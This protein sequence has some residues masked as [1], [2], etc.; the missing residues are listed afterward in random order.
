VSIKAPAASF[1]ATAASI[2]F[3]TISS[4][5]FNLPL[6]IQILVHFF[7]AVIKAG[8]ICTKC[9]ICYLTSIDLTKLKVKLLLN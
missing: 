1:K 3:A 5:A 2:S 4:K 8:Q 6:L 7:E 9:C